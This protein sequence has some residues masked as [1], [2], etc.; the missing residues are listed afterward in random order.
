[1]FPTFYVN[2]GGHCVGTGKFKMDMGM[3]GYQ[4]EELCL[5]HEPLEEKL[6]AQLLML[7]TGSEAA[8]Q[9]AWTTTVH[10]VKGAHLTLALGPAV[11]H[12]IAATIC[13]HRLP[14][15]MTRQGG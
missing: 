15:L 12:C 8:A 6:N 14:L 10:S 9:I 11:Y 7:R 3:L 5:Q 13:F 2:K 1:M 4:G